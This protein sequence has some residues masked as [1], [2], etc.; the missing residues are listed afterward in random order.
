MHVAILLS[1]LLAAGSQAVCWPDS[2]QPAYSHND[3]RQA[4][5]LHDAIAAGLRGI[6]VD[7]FRREQELVVAHDRRHLRHAPTFESAYLHRI[8]EHAKRCGTMLPAHAPFLLCIELKQEDPRAFELL[9]EQLAP[10]RQILAQAGVRIVLVGWWPRQRPDWPVGIAVQRTIEDRV[11][12]SVVQVPVGLVS[13]DYSKTLR[14]RG[15]GVP[16][17]SARRAL[18]DSRSLAIRLGVPL[19]V[20]QAP[21][22]AAVYDW[23]LK[24]GVELIGL[25]SLED[26][27]VL[28]GRAD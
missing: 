27:E 25:K 17:E 2:L 15:H 1:I 22:I 10:Y 6:E 24:E 21:A 12:S 19:R 18:A 23:L 14:W 16:R 4:Q 28:R 13:I 9:L 5:P 26:V 8:A 20:H 3:Y 11:D 7:L